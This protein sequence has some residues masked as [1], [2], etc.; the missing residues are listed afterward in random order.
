MEN[1]KIINKLV[2]KTPVGNMLAVSNGYAIRSLDF[3]DESESMS[4]KDEILS[5]LKNELDEYF[6]GK[7]REFS[8]PLAPVGTPFQ[9]SVWDTLRRIPYGE[10][11][12][13]AKEALML[14]RPSAVRAVANANG[15]NPIS[16]IIPCHRVI[17]SSGGIGGYSGGVW[18]KEFLLSL[19]AK[20]R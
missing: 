3:T 2:V 11:V 15:K 20:W 13:Y 12:S 16:I 10:R 18:R 4:A 6:A 7:R 8:A 9:T 17:S 5:T 19:E 1:Q 14:G